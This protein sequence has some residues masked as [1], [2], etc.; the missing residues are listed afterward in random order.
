MTGKY[1]CYRSPASTRQHSSREEFPR[2]ARAGA[3]ARAGVH[4]SAPQLPLPLLPSHCSPSQLLQNA[5]STENPSK[6]RGNT[7]SLTSGFKSTPPAAW[8][9]LSPEEWGCGD[10][11]TSPC[12]SS[13]VL[14]PPAEIHPPEQVPSHQPRKILQRIIPLAAHSKIAPYTSWSLFLRIKLNKMVSPSASH[15]KAKQRACLNFLPFS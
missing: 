9:D 6:Y 1:G 3:C 15:R 10:E 14:Q 12:G 8:C 4:S 7:A 11:D 5:D 13:S 2:T